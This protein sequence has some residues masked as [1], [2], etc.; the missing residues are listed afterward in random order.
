MGFTAA[1]MQNATPLRK[2]RSGLLPPRCISKLHFEPDQRV[3]GAKVDIQPWVR[4]CMRLFQQPLIT[5]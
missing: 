3:I 2:Y 4:T 5:A 1:F